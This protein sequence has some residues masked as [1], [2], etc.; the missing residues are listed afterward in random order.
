MKI[1][2]LGWELIGIIFIFLLGSLLHFAFDWSGG[3]IPV[4]I[5]AA[6]N[7]S[8][9]EHLKL[10]IWPALVFSLIEYKFLKDSTNNFPVAK[11]VGIYLIPISIIVLFYSYTFILGHGNLIMDILIF[12]VA[13]IIGQLASYKLLTKHQLSPRIN[14]LAIIAIVILFVVFMLFT[15]YPP[16]LPIFM[17]PI[18]GTYG[19]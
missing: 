16:H 15:F 5:I 19:I 17:D 9:W 2:I 14:K 10:G 4:G 7:E 13:I 12:L 1:S 11:A 8:V 6:V 18:S 3:F